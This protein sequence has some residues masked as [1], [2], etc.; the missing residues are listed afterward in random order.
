[1][2]QKL[3]DG[4][5][6]L[7]ITWFDSHF[8]NL[9]QFDS[10]TFRPEN[11]GTAR[12][13]GTESFLNFQWTDNLDL[14]LNHTWNQA[15]DGDGARLLRRAKQK[16]NATLHHNWRNKLDSR[17]SLSYKSNIRDF[18]PGAAGFTTVRV[19]LSYQLLDN[20]KITARGENLFDDD[21]EE[22]PG[23][24]TAGVSG[25]AGLTYNF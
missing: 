3:F 12:S 25:Y 7:G 1:I 8:N 13:N 10:Q 20:L 9:I 5:L 16:L 18:G 2:D 23:F 11:I 24:G 4:R 15:V 17:V 14:S 19:V 6:V 21:H 22:I